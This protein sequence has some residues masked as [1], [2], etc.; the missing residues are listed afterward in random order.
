MP[1]Y[2][3]YKNSGIDWIGTIPE[4]WST[5]KFSYLF[6]LGRGLAITKQDLTDE[7]IPC[8]NYGE[9]HSKFGF[10]VSPE[11]HHLRCVKENYLETSPSS[12]LSRGDFVFADTSEDIEGSGNFTCLNSDTPTFAGYHTV[13]AR[14]NEEHN[15][16]YIAYFFD[17][18]E[19]RNQIRSEVSG[20][21]VFSITQAIL[22]NS[23]VLLPPI[24]EQT[25]IANY[26]DEKTKEIDELIADKK[27]LLELYEEEKKTIIN[28]AV[29]K[30]INPNATMKDSGIEWLGEI[31][32]HWEVSRM[33]NVCKV[34]Q[35][36]QIPIEKRHSISLE[37]SLEYITIRSINNPDNPKEYISNPPENVICHRDDILMARTGATGEPITNVEGV[38]H[39]NFFLIDYNRQLVIKEFL[40]NYLKCSKVKEYLLLVAGTTTIPDLN[41][42]DFYGTPFFEYGIEEQQLIVE[43]IEI[44]SAR[45]NSKIEN[46][47]KLIELLTEY[48]TALISEVVTGKLKVTA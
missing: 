27:K 47:Q 14:Q 19:F 35:G 3:T 41:H 26:L 23:K 45:I 4:H 22:K 29:T 12:L 24:D 32:E 28:Q 6:S 37:G 33:K 46:T 5:Q 44:E 42:S 7:G 38:L 48:R 1:P 31:P 13:I 21:K 17:S 43:Y 30:G 8:V 36:L 11:V 39:N 34:R 25:T 9:I 20:I 2:D 15:Y 16:R 40:F 10:E 18:L